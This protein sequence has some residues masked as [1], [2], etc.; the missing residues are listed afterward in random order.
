VWGHDRRP[1][2]GMLIDQSGQH[3]R[4]V[5]LKVPIV[6]SPQRRP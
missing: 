5:A 6:V 4:K 3:R 2:G 1:P